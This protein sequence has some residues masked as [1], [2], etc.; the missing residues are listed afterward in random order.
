[1]KS[2]YSYEAIDKFIIKMVEKG[3][4]AIQL[5]EGCSGSGSWVLIAPNDY[6][7]NF[8]IREVAISDWS[9]G[10]TIRRCAR[11]SKRLQMEIDAAMDKTA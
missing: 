2:Y 11:I 9:S 10:H 6:Q 5:E 1:M 7:Y 3:Y 4:E 8:V